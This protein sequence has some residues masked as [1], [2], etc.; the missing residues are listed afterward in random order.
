MA[1]NQLCLIYEG[2]IR[3]CQ[4]IDVKPLSFKEWMY[5][6][7]RRRANLQTAPAAQPCKRQR[8]LLI[9]LAEGSNGRGLVVLDIEEAV[10][11][12]DLEQIAD[13]L[14]DVHQL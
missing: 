14:G 4:R 2:Y 3:F 6:S 12:G 11:F 9:P 13:P 10:Q 5:E 1:N 8:S 7:R